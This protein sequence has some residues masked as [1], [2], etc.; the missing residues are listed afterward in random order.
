[1]LMFGG[2]VKVGGVLEDALL[3]LS[4]GQRWVLRADVALGAG[5]G[6]ERHGAA[7]ALVEHLAMSRLNV[8]LDG[9]EPSEHHLAAGTSGP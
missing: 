5:G 6:L 1:M 9:V 3:G 8:G 4:S 2:Q 7:G